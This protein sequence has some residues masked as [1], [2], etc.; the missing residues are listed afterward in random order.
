M[1]FRDE[2]SSY[3]DQPDVITRV[4]LVRPKPGVFIDEI[5]HILVI[6]TPITI[7]LIGIS[8]TPAPGRNGR[9]HNAIQ[10]FAT[11]MSVSIDSEMNSVAGTTDGR[12]FLTGA[13]DG[14]L[15]ELH[16][17][18]SESWFGKRVQLINHSVSGVSSL[19]PRLTSRSEGIPEN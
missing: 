12:I 19:F 2:L 13:D 18:E 6:C 4:A 10:L 9:L 15:Y 14:N 7:L 3:V 5:T 1:S 16:Y 11:D 17:Q 8:S